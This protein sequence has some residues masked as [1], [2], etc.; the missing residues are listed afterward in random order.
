MLEEPIQESKTSQFYHHAIADKV[1]LARRILVYIPFFEADEPFRRPPLPWIRKCRVFLT[2]NG[3]HA[4]GLELL[5]AMGKI[6]WFEDWKDIYPSTDYRL[7]NVNWLA[8]ASKDEM[9]A[10]LSMI[11]EEPLGCAF[12]R[13]KAVFETWEGNRDAR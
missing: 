5:D 4:I 2:R 10:I 12:Y 1:L 11:R 8:P 7:N 3:F 6:E 13:D 9:N